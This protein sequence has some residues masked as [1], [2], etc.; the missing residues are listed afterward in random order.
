MRIALVVDPHALRR[1]VRAAAARITCAYLRVRGLQCTHAGQ[2]RHA[3][4]V[5]VGR[6]RAEETVRDGKWK[7]DF[8]LESLRLFDLSLQCLLKSGGPFRKQ[9]YGANFYRPQ[10]SV[11]TAV[12]KFPVIFSRNDCQLSHYS[13]LSL[14]R[15]GSSRR[16]LSLKP[17]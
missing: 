10:E 8:R 16:I 12:V 1:D 13:V 9:L 14:K 7:Y 17:S 4:R 11:L 5:V 6:G 15:P 2:G 3:D